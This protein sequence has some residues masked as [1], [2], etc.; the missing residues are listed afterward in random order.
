MLRTL[1][2]AGL[3]ALIPASAEAFCGFYVSG[4]EA[5]LYNHATSVVLMRGGVRTVLSMQNNYE[6]P[7]E[8]FA[9][10]V[11]VPV[12]LREQDVKTLRRELFARVDALAAPR[13]VE[14]WEQD[15]CPGDG[16]IRDFTAV[17]QLSPTATRDAMGVRLAGTSGVTVEAEFAVGEYDIVILGARDSS[18]LERWLRGNGYKLPPGAASALRPYVQAGMKFFVA[19]VAID[20]V[21]RDAGGRLTLS[22]LRFHYDSDTFS[23]PVRLGLLNTA[24]AQDLIVHVLAPGTRY[25]AANYPNVVVPTNLDVGEAAL[26][27]FGSF[28]AALFDRVGRQ[29]PGAVVTEYA[30]AAGSCDPC[31]T[32]PLHEGELA[33][34]GADV[35]PPGT[36]VDPGTIVLTRLHVRYGADTLGEDLV[37][38]AA[39]PLVGGRE[40]TDGRGQLEY[41]ARVLAEGDNNFQ[42]RYAVRHPWVGP[43]TCERPMRGLWGGPPSG[44][45]EARVATEL[46]F[47]PRDVPL[48]RFIPDSASS[49]AVV[50]A[51]LPGEAG[52]ASCSLGEGAGGLAGLGLVGLLRRRRRR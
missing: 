35:M 43:I 7:P 36:V 5:S 18:G 1:A 20:R 44:V 51:A 6:G 46:A 9:L 29:A 12:V 48:S 34:L 38:S 33:A 16:T 47:Q 41:G 40:T 52:C 24:G 19:K 37:F 49:G 13:L 4:A 3:L 23:L 31:P 25:Q 27:Q 30:W 15:P 45:M 8:D 2:V 21:T 28:Y 10:V 32:D 26:T 22:P 50:L 14:Y 17:V 39:A 42:A 11:P